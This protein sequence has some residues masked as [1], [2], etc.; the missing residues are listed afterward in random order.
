MTTTCVVL[1]LWEGGQESG[2]APTPGQR[3]IRVGG[4]LGQELPLLGA[5]C[6]CRRR[7]SV[8]QD[9]EVAGHRLPPF[10]PVSSRV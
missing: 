4:S 3:Q 8:K 6:L 7:K 2:L 10:V 1:T 5:S 9:G